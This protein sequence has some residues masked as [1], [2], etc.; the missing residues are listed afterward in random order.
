MDQLM[1]EDLIIDDRVKGIFRVNRRAFT[2]PAVLEMERREV[3]DKSW[4]YAGHVSEIAAP[5]DFVTRRVGG[6]PVILVRDRSETPRAL[7]N[8]C[9][10]RGNIVCREH[11]GSA[12]NFVCFYHA[13]N[14]DL[15]GSLAGVPGEDSYSSAFD[16]SAMGLRPVPRFENYKG[17]LFVCF[18]A[19]T[20]DLISYLGN[21]RE[22]LDYMLDFGGEDVE[23]VRGSQAYSM[24]ANWKLLIENS[25]DGYHAMATH[26]RYFV[27][28]LTDIGAD[29]TA[30]VGPR[31]Q[32]GTGLALGGGHSVIEN[33]L[34][35]TPIM[36]QAKDEL[37]RIRARLVDRFGP[38]RAH[39][40]ADFNRNLFIF[41]NL[42]LISNWHTIR[43]WYPLAPDYI[44]IDAWAA[45][46][47]NDSLELR[48][49]RFENF[50]SFLG[51]A[52]FG[53]PDDVSGLEGCQRGFATQRELP[54][55]DISRGMAREQPT[56]QD[57]LQ[58]RA[59][60]RRW[61]ALMHGE[62]GPTDCSD[63]PLQQRAAAE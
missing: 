46:P 17:M 39:R 62:R 48:Q 60:W 10:H 28:Y 3:F 7:L 61:N 26:H 56:S 40:I 47:R 42:I 45:L 59:F 8:S 11:A 23:I 4:L 20:E 21:A 44:E 16:R 25:I 49:K 1:G 2:D 30:W 29:T 14:F 22:Y 63:R 53:T 15:D 6:R 31:R 32:W 24:K 41:P 37:D 18:D 52:G 19:E 33:P 57:E 5:G 38:E 13:W 58:M 35:P 54:W 34:R 9:P 43:T 51:P 55:S 27:Q 36:T 12:Q 50:I